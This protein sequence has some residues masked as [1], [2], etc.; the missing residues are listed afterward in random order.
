MGNNLQ[1]VQQMQLM[2]Q[3]QA[4]Q[5]MQLAMMD[6]AMRSQVK[7]LSDAV[8][9][10]LPTQQLEQRTVTAEPIQLEAPPAQKRERKVDIEDAEYTVIAEEKKE[11][12]VA[13]LMVEAVYA[14]L[15]KQKKSDNVPAYVIEIEKPVGDTDAIIFAPVIFTVR[16][17]SWR[18]RVRKTLLDTVDL[19]DK[20][21][22]RVVRRESQI[23]PPVLIILLFDGA[24]NVI[25]A[26]A[27][28]H[29][30]MENYT[31]IIPFKDGT[32]EIYSAFFKGPFQP[33]VMPIINEVSRKYDIPMTKWFFQFEPYFEK[34]CPALVKADEETCS[35]SDPISI[36]PLFWFE[37]KIQFISP[38]LYINNSLPLSDVYAR[39]KSV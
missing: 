20:R 15:D 9:A 36:V 32:E 25:E 22:L 12:T 27:L 18:E 6:Q 34:D 5:Q 19:V 3:M 17:A 8:R 29:I 13:D 39:S 30:D 26:I 7:A 24:H 33:I 11:T 37:K 38:E 14:S 35:T 16:N 4:T 10:V 23:H 31:S 2:Q 28:H 1:Q 21:K